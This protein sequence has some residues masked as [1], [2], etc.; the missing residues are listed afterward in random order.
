MQPTAEAIIEPLPPADPIAAEPE[1]ATVEEPTEEAQE[2]A[3]AT[4]SG[5]SHLIV[6]EVALPPSKDELTEANVEQVEDKSHPPMTETARSEAADS[7]DPRAAAISATATP[8][9]ASQQQHQ[10]SRSSTSGYATSALKATERTTTRTP[11]YQR[12]ILDQEE[13]VR[14]P[15]NRDQVDRATVQFGAFNLNGPLDDDIDGDREEP[16]TRAQPPDDSPIAPRA[17]L[18]PI[19]QSAAHVPDPLPLQKPSSSLVPPTGPTGTALPHQP[20]PWALPTNTR[21][22]APSAAPSQP[23]ATNQGWFLTQRFP[24]HISID[25]LMAESRAA[26]QPTIPPQDA[27]LYSRFG[28]NGPQEQPPLSQKSFD[29]FNQAPPASTAQNQ[30]EATYPNQQQSQ[31][32][33]NPQPGGAFSSAPGEYS[34]YYT[35]DPQNRGPYSYYNQPFGQQQSSQGPQDGVPSQQRS[36]SNYNAPQSEN[37]SQYPQSGSQPATSRYGAVSGVVSGVDAQNSGSNTPNIPGAPGQQQQAAAQNQTAQSQS[38]GQQGQQGQQGQPQDYPY[39]HPYFASPYYAAYMNYQGGY[40]QGAYGAPYGKGGPYGQPHQY[41]ISPQGP[42]G[43]SSSPASGFGQSSLPSLHRA[44]S[45]AGGGLGDYGRAG[46]AQS[47]VQPGL[48]GSFGAGVH[49]SFGRAASSY[50]SQGAQSFNSQSSQPGNAPSG[51]DD[52]KPFGDP[53]TGSGPSPSL[54]ASARPGSA[55]NNAPS[56]LPPVQSGQGM[57]AYGSYPSHLQGHGPHG[58]HS[59]AGGYGMGTGGQ[60]AHGS[61][62]YGGYGNQGGGGFGGNY[63]SNQ[64]PRGWGNNYH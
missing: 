3:P 58:G 53:K 19:P 50:Q 10:S 31:Q 24:Q 6:P 18:P 60:Q 52:L 42:Y 64:Q 23:A 21:L 17:S 30:Y 44:D 27:R 51:A 15:G 41:G 7:W 8:L 63:H 45:G 26:A 39:N 35:A 59:G 4:I 36:F 11:S 33:Q 38:H 9:S 55:T 62:P 22:P 47:G 37:L 28:Q 13:A 29:L 46:S 34:S 57:S 32:A 56:H 43:H 1:P 49:D 40:N 48:S 14:M 12:R 16:E 2:P 54:G 5:S 25:E 20:S 61:G